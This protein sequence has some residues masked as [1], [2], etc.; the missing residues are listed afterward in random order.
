MVKHHRKTLTEFV[1]VLNLPTILINNGRY[2]LS[3]I[4]THLQP[5]KKF[6]YLCLLDSKFPFRNNK[7]FLA[8]DKHEIKV[9]KIISPLL[10][11]DPRRN[12]IINDLLNKITEIQHKKN[13]LNVHTLYL[14]LDLCHMD[15]IVN[16]ITSVPHDFK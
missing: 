9:I 13:L 2:N 8:F 16:L 6:K 10:K 1:I 12:P 4:N 7:I 5:V 14:Q 11:L 3:L 15:N